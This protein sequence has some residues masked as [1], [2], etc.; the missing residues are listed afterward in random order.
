[1][2]GGGVWWVGLWF[3]GVDEEVG[4]VGCFLERV[5]GCREHIYVPRERRVRYGT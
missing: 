4:R 2:V 3:G 5:D 1:M